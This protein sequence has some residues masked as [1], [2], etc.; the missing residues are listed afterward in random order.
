VMGGGTSS[1]AS[2]TAPSALAPL[3]LSHEGRHPVTFST[4]WIS[5]TSSAEFSG[6]KSMRRSRHAEEG[7]HLC[8][9]EHLVF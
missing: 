8:G 5:S 1:S 9:G 7:K 3:L 4:L 2:S 6:T